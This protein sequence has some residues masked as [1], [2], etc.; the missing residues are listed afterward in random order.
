MIRNQMERTNALK[1]AQELYDRA[2]SAARQLTSDERR[3]VQATVD[4]V[5][6]FDAKAS[7]PNLLD[8]INAAS[9][10]GQTIPGTDSRG[11]GFDGGRTEYL[12]LSSKALTSDYMG[13]LAR[14]DGAKALAPSGD[15]TVGLPLVNQTPITLGRPLASFLQAIPTVQRAPYY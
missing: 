12:D 13:K 6:A 5:K 8:Q 1:S 14:P 10:G 11:G 9:G 2:K 4:D 7:E 3:L 15:V